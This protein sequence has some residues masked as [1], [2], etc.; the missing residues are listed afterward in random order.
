MFSPLLQTLFNE[1]APTTDGL[2]RQS[3]KYDNKRV[4]GRSRARACVCHEVCSLLQTRMQT[5]L[6]FFI[7][8]HMTKGRVIVSAV[9]SDFRTTK[10]SSQVLNPGQLA[11]KSN[12]A[13]WS[14][15]AP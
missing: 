9:K 12:T 11:L 14:T 6:R 4:R 10:L 5:L 8:A 2:R 1:T 15:T 3:G 7:N 13:G